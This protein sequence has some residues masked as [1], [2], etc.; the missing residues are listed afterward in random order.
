MEWSGLFLSA[1]TPYQLE[2]VAGPWE[3]QQLD[4][5]PIFISSF[6]WD[7]G[8]I[9]AL[10]RTF[11]AGNQEECACHHHSLNVNPLEIFFNS[12]VVL[13]LVALMLS[14]KSLAAVLTESRTNDTFEGMI[15][16]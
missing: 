9:C 1:A 2:A 11:T 10:A 8:R 7:G 3:D 5:C 16:N 4:K 13:Y 15:K 6:R 12:R 14:V